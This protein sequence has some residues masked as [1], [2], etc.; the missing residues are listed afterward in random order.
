MPEHIVFI[1]ISAITFPI[2]VH[3]DIY[4]L[5]VRKFNPVINLLIFAEVKYGKYTAFIIFSQNR[6]HK[7][8]RG[9]TVQPFKTIIIIF[10]SE[11]AGWER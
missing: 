1:G 4:T 11:K 9:V 10:F 5:I 2:T 7:S 6:V 8:V 3:K